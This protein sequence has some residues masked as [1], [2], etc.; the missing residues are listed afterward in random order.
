M[1]TSINRARAARVAQAMCGVIKQFLAVKTGL[2]SGGG[3]TASTSSAA[4][5]SRPE[6]S[7][8]ASAASSTSGPRLVLSKNAVGFISASRAA[9]TTSL[10]SGVSGQ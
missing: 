2:A 3:S 1:L 8:D 10:V 5:A 4:P 6:L 9:L 7:A